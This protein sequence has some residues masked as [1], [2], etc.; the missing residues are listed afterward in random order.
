M[1]RA[2]RGGRR[3]TAA[4]AARRGTRVEELGQATRSASGPSTCSGSPDLQERSREFAVRIDDSGKPIK[5]VVD[6]DVPL[7]AA[8]C[9]LRGW[10]DKLDYAFSAGCDARSASRPSS[11]RNFPPLMLAWTIAPALAAGNTVVLP[12]STTPL[13]APRSQKCVARA[14]PRRGSGQHHHRA[15]RHRDGPPVTIRGVD[16][17]ASHRVDCGG[18]ADR[19]GIVSHGQGAY[20]ELGVRPPTSSPRTPHWDQAVEGDRQPDLLPTRARRVCCAGRGCVGPGSRSPACSSTSF[21]DRRP[22]S[23]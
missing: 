18:Q 12:A 17:V 4:A 19:P 2:S 22:P 10:A 3:R 7:A 11:S 8:H 1:A 5:R 20:L 23:G 15:A 21:G 9:V 6:V 14:S 16:K 13:R